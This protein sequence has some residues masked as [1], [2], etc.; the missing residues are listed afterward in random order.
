MMPEFMPFAG[1]SPICWAVLVQMEH[2]AEALFPQKPAVSRQMPNTSTPL[3]MTNEFLQKYSNRR[4]EARQ[5]R[6]V[7]LKP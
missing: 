3:F 1:F 4:R 6:S 5:A 2:W 7:P